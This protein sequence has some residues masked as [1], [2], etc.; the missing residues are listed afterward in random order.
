MPEAGLLRPVLTH[1]VSGV[2]SP[3]EMGVASWVFEHHRVAGRG[4]DTEETAQALYVPLVGLEST[5]GVLSWQP[6]DAAAVISPAHR[7]FLEVV[8]TQVA[9]SLERDWLSRETERILS[10]ADAERA[11]SSLLSVVSHDLRTPLAAIAG[12]AS[13]LVEDTL[14]VQ[15][16]KELAGTIYEEADRLARLV[17]NL[18]QLTRI[19]SGAMK[20]RKQWQPLEE[21]IGSSLRRIEGSRTKHDGHFDRR[22]TCLWCRWMA[23]S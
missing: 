13:S 18:L 20:V 11:R 6:D 3:G 2:E 19:E 16:R 4:T 23:C 12:S 10:E 9:L 17:D 22:R 5:I 1:G 8:A 21:V 7:E 14:D 15:T